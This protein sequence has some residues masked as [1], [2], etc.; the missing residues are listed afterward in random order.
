MLLVADCAADKFKAHRIDFGRG[1]LD[2]V[3]DLTEREGVKGAF[4]PIALTVNGVK[5]KT[6]RL[7]GGPPVGEI[8]ASEALHR[9]YPPPRPWPRQSLGSPNPIETASIAALPI[10]VR[11]ARRE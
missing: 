4:V 6:G 10:M 11:S 7:G 2:L 3:L 5:F 8:M 9:H 1:R